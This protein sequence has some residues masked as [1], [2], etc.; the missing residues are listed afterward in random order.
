MTMLHFFSILTGDRYATVAKHGPVSRRKVIAMG[1]GL[2]LVTGLWFFIGFNLGMNAFGMKPFP[3]LALGASMSAVVFLV[4]RMVLLSSGKHWGIVVSRIALALLMSFLGGI[5]LDL[6][7]L[8]AEIDQTVV[9]MHREAQAEMAS[10]LAMG[11]ADKQNDLALVVEHAR[12]ELAAAEAAWLKELD[13]TGGTGRYGAGA[14]ARSKERLVHDR[15]GA[16]ADAQQRADLLSQKI[17]A[18]QLARTSTLA[19]AQRATGLFDRIHAMKNYIATDPLVRIVYLLLTLLLI[20]VELS[21]LVVKYGFPTTAYEQG[22]EAANHM[23]CEQV[24]LLAHKQEQ[25]NARSAA[26]SVEELRSRARLQAITEAY[27]G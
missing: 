5:G 14:V 18:E 26:M 20:L 6:Y 10:S 11:Y 16:L 17:A 15:K 4:D 21:P 23:H 3:A 24:R 19:Q 12:Q 7:I 27:Q 13:G 25:F 9:G 1:S 22:I 8:R 2:L